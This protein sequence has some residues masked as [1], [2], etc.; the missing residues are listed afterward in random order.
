M[1]TAAA[2]ARETQTETSRIAIALIAL[3]VVASLVYQFVKGQPYPFNVITK[4]LSIS[5]LAVAA[6]LVVPRPAALLLSAALA[7]SSLGDVLLDLQPQQFTAGLASFLLAHVL[8]IPLFLR[9]KARELDIAK[10]LLPVALIIYAAMFAARLLPALNSG[11][12]MPVTLYLCVIT[13]MAISASL[14][15][16]GAPWVLIGALLFLFSDS[17]LAAD[18]FLSP[19]AYRNWLVWPSYY[20]AQFAILWGVW[21]RTSN[22]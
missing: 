15:D 7:L 4:G 2:P 14:A 1:P 16:F 6:L 18:R 17:V 8:Y 9:N 13:A 10:W 19:I 5:P 20:L 22:R 11:M 21:H 12:K 3:S